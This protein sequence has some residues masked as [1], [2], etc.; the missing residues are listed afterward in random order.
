MATAQ[1]GT[2]DSVDVHLKQFVI[3]LR[4]HPLSD[5]VCSG[6]PLRASSACGHCHGD[7]G[8]HACYT[9]LTIIIIY[10]I[11]YSNN[12]PTTPNASSLAGHGD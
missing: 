5:T 8:C 2:V 11:Q 4:P 7:V 6:N 12:S 10:K 1:Y 9:E 3:G